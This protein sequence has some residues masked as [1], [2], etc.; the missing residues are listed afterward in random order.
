MDK[1]ANAPSVAFEH[2]FEADE[3]R[4]KATG[5]FAQAQPQQAAPVEH[6]VEAV[7]P[8]LGEPPPTGQ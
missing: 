7:A 8:V 1:K 6:P 5:D 2:A 3:T 4:A